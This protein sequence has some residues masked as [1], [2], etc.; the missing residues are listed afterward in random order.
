[1]V[2]FHGPNVVAARFTD[3][4]GNL[5]LGVHGIPNHYFIP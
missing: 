1:L 4:D 5:S 3:L 2:T